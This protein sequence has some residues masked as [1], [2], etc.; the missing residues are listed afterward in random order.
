ME[1]WEFIWVAVIMFS[2]ITFTYMSVKVIYKG[3]G[4]LKEMLSSLSK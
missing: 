2:T 3:I 1:T 4:E